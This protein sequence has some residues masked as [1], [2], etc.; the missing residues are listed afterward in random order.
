MIFF[1][2]EKLTSFGMIFRAL[3]AAKMRVDRCAVPSRE[4]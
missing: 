1:S 3:F 4:D 2:S